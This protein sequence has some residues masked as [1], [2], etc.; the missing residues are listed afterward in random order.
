MATRKKST[1][2]SDETIVNIVGAS[3]GAQDFL[4]K[5]QNLIL[6]VIGGLAIII[7]GYFAYV[8]LYQNPRQ[9]EAVEQMF[10]AQFQ[11]EQD[12]FALALS[13]PGG[14]Y[15][16]FLDIIDNY[17]GTPAANMAKYYAGIC[18][19]NLGQYDSAVEYLESYKA[20]G[21]VTPIMKF[22]ALGDAYSELGDMDKAAAMYKK[23]ANYE[24]NDVL[25]PYYLKKLGMLLEH[26]N[27]MEGAL[28]AYK[29]IKKKYPTSPDASNIDKFIVRVEGQ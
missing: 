19:L 18:Y 17:G 12:S 26:E 8:N 24:D 23:A 21:D 10:Q 16:G 2:N 25:T 5:N 1:A 15:G 6:G 11:F 13:N 3:E 22:G 4:E 7:G 27:D 28:K 20:K 9:D 14:G 29:E